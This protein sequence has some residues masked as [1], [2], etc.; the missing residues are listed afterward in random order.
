MSS[1]KAGRTCALGNQITNWLFDLDPRL[2]NQLAVL[3]QFRA[4]E[5]TEVLGRIADAIAAELA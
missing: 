1:V 3:I 2:L 5:I 4:H